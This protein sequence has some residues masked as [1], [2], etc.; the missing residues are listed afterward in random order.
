[1]QV[2]FFFVTLMQLKSE[3]PGQW[4][5]TESMC[6][7]FANFIFLRGNIRTFIKITQILSWWH[8]IVLL[9]IIVNKIKSV[10]LN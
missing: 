2:K 7:Y 1:M 8:F 3:L 4:I 10:K 9:S 6:F 5:C